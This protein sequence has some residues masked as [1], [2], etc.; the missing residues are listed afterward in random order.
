MKKTIML[1]LAVVLTVCS[2]TLVFTASAGTQ[3]EQGTAPSDRNYFS[4]EPMYI[5]NLTFEDK[6]VGTL[7]ADSVSGMY[8]VMEGNGGGM[9]SLMPVH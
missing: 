9:R 3:I 6:D 7:N 5:R 4:T 2:F 1:L 8:L